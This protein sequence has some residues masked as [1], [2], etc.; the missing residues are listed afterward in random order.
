MLTANEARAAI[1]FLDRCTL[2]GHKERI[3]MNQII[4]KL[5]AIVPPEELKPEHPDV[6]KPETP[7]INDEEADQGT[8]DGET[9]D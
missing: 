4:S 1:A 9:G 2:N 6:E 8:G 5:A 7:G 3:A